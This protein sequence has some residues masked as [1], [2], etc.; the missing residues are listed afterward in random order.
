MRQEGRTTT[1]EER[2]E[3]GERWEAVQTDDEIAQAMGRSQWTVRKWRR[4]YQHKG[5]AGLA[6][7]MG[8]PRTGA[9]G[10]LPEPVRQAIR[11]M[12]EANPGWGPDTI[13][14][15]W[16]KDP[17]RKDLPRPSRSRIAAFLKATHGRANGTP[18]CLNQRRRMQKRC[19]KNGKWT[20]R[21]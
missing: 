3:I 5:R 21:V 20:L 1:L 14:A 19:M 8:R 13:R 11:E 7:H 12:R 18:N 9:L 16:G 6:S 15:E 2:I 10:S 4:K 17:T